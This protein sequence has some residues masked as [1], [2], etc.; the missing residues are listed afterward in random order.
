MPHRS[1]VFYIAAL[2]ACWSTALLAQPE[3]LLVTGTASNL[4]TGSVVYRE[5]H[6]VSKEQHSVRYVD[7]ANKLIA[8][9]FVHY[10]HGFNTPEYQLDDKRFNRRTGSKWENGHF[11]IFRQEKSG[12][13]DRKIIKSDSNM[14]IDA[15]FDHFIRLHWDELIDG[16]VLPFSLAVA[17]PLTILHMELTEMSAVQTAIKQRSDR[18]RYFL[19]HSS[20]NLIGWAIPEMH[21]AYDRDTKL[22]QIYQ[23]P[24]NLTDQ[25]DKTQTVVIRYEYRMADDKP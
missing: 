8:S 12:K 11:V 15:G 24:S 18:Y 13:S 5:Y 2:L 22:I 4:K 1:P 17:D 6:N 3:K 14:V 21:M 25:D 23:G 9:K 7:A 10:Q 19:V 16:K 20:N